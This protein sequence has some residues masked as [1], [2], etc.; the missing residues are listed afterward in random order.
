MIWHTREDIPPEGVRILV[1]SPSY[2]RLDSELRWQIM[3]SFELRLWDEATHW[4]V[5]EQNRPLAS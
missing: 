1:F 5:L 4:A 2:E 3:D